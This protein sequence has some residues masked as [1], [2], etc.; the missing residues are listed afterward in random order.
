[1]GMIVTVLCIAGVVL[2]LLV[3]AG[4]FF[5]AN[6]GGRDTVST[7]RQDWIQRRSDTDDRGW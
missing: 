2:A 5:V 4:L 7:A 3:A 6:A 1:M